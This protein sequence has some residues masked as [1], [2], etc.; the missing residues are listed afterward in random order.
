MILEHDVD[1]RII[2]TLADQVPVPARDINRRECS[3][4]TRVTTASLGI[5]RGISSKRI[6]FF[7]SFNLGENIALL[8]SAS[9]VPESMPVNTGAPERPCYGHTRDPE[10]GELIRQPFS[11]SVSIAGLWCWQW[12]NGY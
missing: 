1:A 8:L 2:A 10:P 7:L 11:P 12:A 4:G 5:G 6:T 9:S 3:L